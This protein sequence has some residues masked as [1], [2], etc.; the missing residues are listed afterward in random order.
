[1]AEVHD[2]DVRASRRVFAGH[3]IALR[4]DDVA[5]PGG[6]LSTRDV[7]EH[8]G[9]VAVVALD[10]AGRVVLVNQYRHPL[11]E[12]LWELSA[13]L[14][15]M[16]G[17]SAAAAAARE[18]R[19]EAGLEAAEWSVLVDM[20]TSPGMTDEAIRIYLARRLRFVGRPAGDDEEAE[21]TVEHVDLDE[22]VAQVLSGDLRNGAACVGIL[23]AAVARSHGFAGLRPAAAAWPDRSGR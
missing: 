16:A 10:D 19:E 14:L 12:R 22:A 20:L 6:G 11:K 13:G 18:L 21:I 5:M 3:V 7:V 17:E 1:M 15:D 4:S 2:Y 23:A 8:P 9:A